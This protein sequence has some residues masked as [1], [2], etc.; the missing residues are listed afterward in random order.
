MDRSAHPNHQRFEERS[1]NS[2]E[3]ALSK[4]GK[5]FF[6]LFGPATDFNQHLQ[7]ADQ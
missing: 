7:M 1:T 2:I 3:K 6:N 4:F 5:K